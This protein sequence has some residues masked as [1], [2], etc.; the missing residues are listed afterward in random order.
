MALEDVGIVFAE[1]KESSTEWLDV[2]LVGKEPMPST[3]AT[4]EQ[5][6]RSDRSD[7]SDDTGDSGNVLDNGGRVKIGVEAP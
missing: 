1:H 6:T 2:A 4:S 5:D 7:A 3:E